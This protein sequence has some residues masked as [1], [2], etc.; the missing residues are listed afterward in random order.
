MRQKKIGCVFEFLWR[1]FYS[2]FS[3]MI[4]LF[5]NF[6]LDTTV[7]QDWVYSHNLTRNALGISGGRE[8]KQGRKRSSAPFQSILNM[9][10]VLLPDFGQPLV[11]KLPLNWISY[12]QP[13][14]A[15]WIVLSMMLML[16]YTGRF[17]FFVQAEWQKCNQYI[18][19]CYTAQMDEF[20]TV[21]IVFRH[22][23]PPLKM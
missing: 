15:Y 8:G 22:L 20:S 21:P 23:I 13:I 11:Y 5:I 3:G 7:Y 10:L 9:Y 6:V 17:L 4:A 12:A 16:P 19:S 1:F 2:I 14:A 18:H